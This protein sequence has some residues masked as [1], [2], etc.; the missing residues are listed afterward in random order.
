MQQ[1]EPTSIL[2]L[3]T[4]WT[5]TLLSCWT[6]Q[7]LN[8]QMQYIAFSCNNS[9]L[10][11]CCCAYRKLHLLLS[12]LHLFR[13][14]GLIFSRLHFPRHTAEGDHVYHDTFSKIKDASVV[15][16]LV[17]H[18]SVNTLHP[19]ICLHFI[20]TTISKKPKRLCSTCTNRW[21]QVCGLNMY[22]SASFKPCLL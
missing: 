4:T 8:L 20:A 22:L 21:S 13:T 17:S 12:N 2:I 18:S 10:M 7:G 6:E 9:A 15:G 1:G 11:R 16:I 3:L 14:S 19:L 5:T